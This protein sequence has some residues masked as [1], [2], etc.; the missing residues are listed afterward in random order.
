MSKE[1]KGRK[2]SKKVLLLEPPYSNKYPPMGL[3]KIATYFR[4]HRKYDVRFFKGDL[5][6]LAADMLLEKLLQEPIV[7]EY[8]EANEWL[9]LNTRCHK[10]LR[11]YIRYGRS[12]D[13]E[14]LKSCIAKPVEPD[15]SQDDQKGEVI[16]LIEAYRERYKDKDYEKFD[17]I[18]VT[19]LFTFYWKQTIDC[20]EQAKKFL[21]KPPKNYN[22]PQKT[23]SHLLIGGILATLLPEQVEKETGIKTKGGE[24]V[25]NTGIKPL[26]GIL[27][28]G[29]ME[30][31]LGEIPSDSEYSVCQYSIVDELD[32][33]YSILWEVDYVYPANNAYYAYTTRGCVNKCQFCAVPT[34]EPNYCDYIGIKEQI[35]KTKER[36]GDKKDLL[37]L[38]NNVFASKEYEKI[39]EEIKQ[40]GF[41]K[42]AKYTPP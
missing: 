9:F 25:P 37:L 12:S 42:G 2:S 36:Y 3:M 19:T 18:C 5:K 15:G 41:A 32:L 39:I 13:I 38:D 24:W 14:H 8:L 6:D 1:N 27:K 33:D 10:T 31:S 30:K 28:A 7:H 17:I 22:D 29:D 35:D 21:K 23:E 34:L 40:C 16:S 26:R 20:I 4:E 11:D